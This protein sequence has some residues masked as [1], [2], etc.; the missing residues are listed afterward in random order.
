MQSMHSHTEIENT[1]SPG[2]LRALGKKKKVIVMNTVQK[3]AKGASISNKYLLSGS[4][5]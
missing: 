1:I 3:N 2:I 4:M 5:A